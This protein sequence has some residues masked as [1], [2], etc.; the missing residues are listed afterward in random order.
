MNLK[1]AM[2]AAQN[3]QK[4]SQ[5]EGQ[6][7]MP[8][9]QA[10]EVNPIAGNTLVAAEPPA[11]VVVKKA[12]SPLDILAHQRMEEIQKLNPDFA[13]D[14][15]NVFTR[16]KINTKG[17]FMY[18]LSG[19]DFVLS[20]RIKI[21]LL[22]GNYMHQYWGEK[23]SDDEGNLVCYS[24]D[25]QTTSV[26]GCSCDKCPYDRSKCHVRFAIAFNVLE[27][28]EDHE[29]VY[30]LNMPQTGAFAFY[31]YIKLLTKKYKKGLKE[32]VTEMYTEEKDGKEK[33]QKFNAIQFTISK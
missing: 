6:I 33:G 27:D 3:A 8:E 15:M 17:K 29:E 23:G 30:N 14:N 7:E 13:L 20:D 1:E 12:P 22:A 26:D 31:D 25:N 19:E 4:A 21:R 18:T 2:E 16:L 32:V 24:E 10:V 9:A 5:I 28:G 11:A